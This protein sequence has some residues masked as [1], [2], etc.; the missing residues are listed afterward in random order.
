MTVTPDNSKPEKKEENTKT[1]EENKDGDRDDEKKKDP[2]ETKLC[3]RRPY[4]ETYADSQSFE[5]EEVAFKS[6][7]RGELFWDKYT[8]EQARCLY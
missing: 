2:E 3:L 4:P 7:K 8:P 6:A 5:L 1:E